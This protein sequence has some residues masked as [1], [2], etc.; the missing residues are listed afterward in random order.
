[1]RSPAT[2]MRRLLPWP[3]LA[4]RARTRTAPMWLFSVAPGSPASPRALRLWSPS[5]CSAPSKPARSR[6]S[7]RPKPAGAPNPPL[8]STALV[9]RRRWR[10]CWGPPEHRSNG[11]HGAFPGPDMKLSC[12]RDRSRHGLAHDAEGMNALS[13]MATEAMLLDHAREIIVRP[14][15]EDDVAAML[16]IYAHHVQR[17]LGAFDLEPLH[18]DDI[19]RRRKNMLKRK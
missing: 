4:R 9:L 11:S 8:P 3:R 2:R 7:P 16:A 5:R 1:M 19:K 15:T 6:S 13:S 12:G 17:G 14:S 18:P 10:S